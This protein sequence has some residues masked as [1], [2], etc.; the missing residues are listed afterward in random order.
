MIILKGKGVAEGVACGPVFFYDRT[1]PEV[2]KSTASDISAEKERFEAA[3][4]K[5][6]A[7]LEAL[8]EKALERVGEAEAEIFEIHHMMLDDMDYIDAINALIEG[9][10][11]NAEYAVDETAKSFAEV[12]SSMEDNEYMQARAA[13]V[14]D[15]SDR[16]IGILTG[17]R[18]ELILEEPSIILTDDLMPSET[19]SV[20]RSLLL[21]I[22]TTAGSANS[23]TA[24]LSRTMGIP[25]LVMLEGASASLGGRQAVLDSAAGTLTAD[26]DE[27]TLAAYEE[28]RAE[29]EEKKKLLAEMVGKENRT[30]DGKTVKLFANIGSPADAEAALA[31]D[32][33]GVGLFRS[34]FLYLESDNY[35]DEEKQFAAYKSVL[36]QMQ[37]REVVIRT[38]DIGADK[39]IDYFG[40]PEE[41]N[42]ALGMR[43]LRI[44][45]ERPGI[46][47]TQLRALFR[48]SAFGKLL[49]MFPMVVSEWEI[50]EIHRCV[51][52]VKAELEN[53]GLAFDENVKLGIMVETPAAAVMS[54]V[55]AK[56]VDFFSIG[57]NDLTQYTLAAESVARFAD[58]HNEA[59]LRLIELTAKNAH[60]A[61]I[62]VGI[63]GEL[64][65]DIT[66]T[67]R[68]LRAGI[69]EL[70]MSPSKILEVR[71]QVR[72]LTIE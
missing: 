66:L 44:C 70:S 47:K 48:A 45:L 10:S 54:D 7:E 71:R 32:A 37:G 13:D 42:P 4:Q 19:V 69:D 72:S 22:A 25:A 49:I 6:G 8:Q 53:E 35:P 3:R 15:I 65:S 21:G 51:D 64:A 62:W 41:E 27:Q 20:D 14:R 68:F 23:H 5:A 52:E 58:T 40:L 1:K 24:I 63:C 16:V 38:L 29:L 61:G 26:P 30:K 33:G 11:V 56:K 2:L 17:K 39:R 55:F 46:F 28:K 59:V 34:E 50:D 43:A 57:T 31:N 18:G 36:E 9:E 67:E 12:F 60:A